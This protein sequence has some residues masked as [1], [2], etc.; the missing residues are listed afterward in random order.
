MDTADFPLCTC[1]CWHPQL[2]PGKSSVAAGAEPAICLAAVCQLDQLLTCQ[3]AAAAP[4]LLCREH[5]AAWRQHLVCPACGQFCHTGRFYLCQAGS[6]G[7]SHLCHLECAPRCESTQQVF[8]PHCG[9]E[10]PTPCQVV[11]FKASGSEQSEAVRSTELNNS[12]RVSADDNDDQS[13]DG[14]QQLADQVLDGSHAGLLASAMPARRPPPDAAE[15]LWRAASAGNF[16][17]AT[18][19]LLHSGASP[20][21]RYPKRKGRCLLHACALSDC[22]PLAQL[23]LAARVDADCLDYSR[24]SPLLLATR[25]GSQSVARLLLSAGADANAADLGGHTPAHMAAVHGWCS[26]LRSLFDA[27]P[28]LLDR[29]DLG[30]WTPAM[31]AAESGQ[32]DCLVRLLDWGA[33]PHRVDRDGRSLLHLAAL[34]FD[35]PGLVTALLAKGC[36]PNQPDLSGDTALHLACAH[37]HHRAAFALCLAGADPTA[38]NKKRET[39][40]ELCRD[41]QLRQRMEAAAAAAAAAAVAG[42]SGSPANGAAEADNLPTPETLLHRD[43][44]RGTEALPLPLYS[45][46]PDVEPPEFFYCKELRESPHLPVDRSATIVTCDCRDGR[47]DSADGCHCVRMSKCA[48][49]DSAGCL[50]ED[51]LDCHSS[52]ACIFEC[53]PLC[54]C[55]ANCKNR[56]V[57]R[58]VRFNCSVF[59]TDN[60]RGW[61]LRAREFIPTGGYVCTYSGE[62]IT[63]TEA[64]SRADD[65]YL[66]DVESHLQ[67]TTSEAGDRVV[68][69]VG[70]APAPGACIDALRIGTGAR[71]INHACEPNMRPVRVFPGSHQDLRYP[72]LCFF[73]CAP[74]APGEELCFDYGEGY[75][76]VKG[77]QMACR[78]RSEACRYSAEKMPELLAR[79]TREEDHAMAP[80]EN[81]ANGSSVSSV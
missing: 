68:V 67:T 60:G 52:E 58:G 9:Q 6:N 16:R 17:K 46:N 79:W 42:A 56:V 71:F 39:P 57:Q 15:R 14:E 70:G 59:L 65:S 21:Q 47:C 40:V 63:D 72:S 53:S 50:T 34:R 69:L 37:G 75:W 29:P 27:W 78:C 31:C 12:S 25:K 49:Y 41:L 22:V 5:L 44:S 43:L 80:A 73:T 24:R 1:L 4:A 33:S 54:S 28:G 66:F 77:R 26:F 64:D 23:L 76:R 35:K 2:L 7:V 11:Q 38:V 3:E 20:H 32:A 48:A 36:N 8:C 45:H 61:G 30:G 19:L 55:W 10:G 18:R 81:G 74:V 62:L 13:S 51:F